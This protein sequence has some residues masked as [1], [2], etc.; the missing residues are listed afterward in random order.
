M[1]A[2]ATAAGY[3]YAAGILTRRR[4]DKT[5]QEEVLREYQ[6]QKQRQEH[7]TQPKITYKRRRLP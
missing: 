6:E 2:A 5:R 7:P 1:S 4:D 3:L